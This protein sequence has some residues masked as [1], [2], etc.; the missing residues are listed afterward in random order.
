MTLDELASLMGGFDRPVVNRTGITAPV[1]YRVEFAREDSGGYGG[2]GEA[3]RASWLAA[4]RNQ[5]GLELREGKGPRD[6]LIVDGAERP[7]PDSP[8]PSLAEGPSTQTSST[9]APA[10]NA[11]ATVDKPARFDVVSVK[12]CPKDPPPSGPAAPAGFRRGGAPWHPTV[13]PGY[14]F[15]SCAT[16]AQLVDQAYADQ[17][18]PLLNIIA[19]PRQDLMNQP[20]RVR[21]G[22]SWVETEKFTIEAKAPVDLTR[23]GLAGAGSR[24]LPTLPAGMAQALRAVL[25]DRFKVQVR[26]ATEEQS[27]LALTIA[28]AGL[29]KQL[30]T[31]PVKGD[32]LNTA[33]YSAAVAAGDVNPVD[34]ELRLCGR[35]HVSLDRGLRFSSFTFEGLAKALSGMFDHYVLDKTGVEAPFNFTIKTDPADGA[36]REVLFSRAIERLGLKLEPT[37]GPAEYL[38]IDRAERPTPNFPAAG[39]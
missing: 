39:R 1:S 28:K 17:D 8:W 12:P 9:F 3:P 32:C 20:K 36:S 4:L 29:N 5:A 35:Y 19:N 18:H 14:A 31:D 10:Q 23:P 7:T 21:G 11:A 13:S 33:E 38:V 6:F 24:V 37:R 16:L 27:M 25:E 15:W 22:P 30:V 34:P 26:R 2:G